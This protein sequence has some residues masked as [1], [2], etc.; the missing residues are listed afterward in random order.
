M[1]SERLR[2][3]RSVDVDQ[4]DDAADDDDVRD[5]PDEGD[6]VVGIALARASVL[7]ERWQYAE[8]DGEQ[9]DGNAGRDEG[10]R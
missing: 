8:Q 2:R 5:Q 9:R 7:G 10:R 3:G 4:R 6:G 1:P